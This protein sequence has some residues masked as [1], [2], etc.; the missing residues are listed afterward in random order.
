MELNKLTHLPWGWQGPT[1]VRQPG[2]ASYFE[3]RIRELPDFF[4]AGATR[5]EALA[6]S[7]PALRAFLQSYVDNG[8]IPPLPADRRPTWLL[9]KVSMPS[10]GTIPQARPSQGATLTS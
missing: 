3:I 8:E 10:Q 7:G 1:E 9:R 4:V 2:T 6:Q 5:E